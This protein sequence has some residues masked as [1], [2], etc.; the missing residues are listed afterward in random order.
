[1]LPGT[2]PAIHHNA[3]LCGPL[4]PYYAHSLWSEH[5]GYVGIDRDGSIFNQVP[6]IQVGFK[7]GT[8]ISSASAVFFPYTGFE[9]ETEYR[10]ELEIFPS[11]TQVIP[12]G[13]WIRGTV[14]KAT[15]QTIA[16]LTYFMDQTTIDPG[17]CPSKYP[18][19]SPPQ[20]LDALLFYGLMGYR[21]VTQFYDFA[22]EDTHWPGPPLL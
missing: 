1:M 15:G 14:K 4:R 6:G 19:D 2:D 17:V 7:Y 11:E 16:S 21:S 8:L 10:L 9:L 18:E 20:G 3:F 5:F 12:T 13:C 22:W